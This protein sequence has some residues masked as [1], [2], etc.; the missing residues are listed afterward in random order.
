MIVIGIELGPRSI[1]LQRHYFWQIRH[2]PVD[3]V[4]E[5]MLLR[6]FN[7]EGTTFGG[8]EESEQHSLWLISVADITCCLV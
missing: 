1:S 6:L 2:A 8:F 4:E 3:I 7:Q 5:S